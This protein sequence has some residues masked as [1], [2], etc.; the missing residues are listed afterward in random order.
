MSSAA[1]VAAC[2]WPQTSS[3]RRRL[4]NTPSRHTARID[5]ARLT[6]T[7][8]TKVLFEHTCITP[9]TICMHRLDSNCHLVS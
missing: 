5:E 6:N 2:A 7:A 9:Y 8:A 3:P 4:C 1:S